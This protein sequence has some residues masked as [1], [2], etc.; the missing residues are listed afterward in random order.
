MALDAT[1][2]RLSS[3]TKLKGKGI[4]L[5]VRQPVFSGEVETVSPSTVNVYGLI[6]GR[7]QTRGVEGNVK[8]DQVVGL[9]AGLVTDDDGTFG[10]ALTLAQGDRIVVGT[11]K[12]LVDDPRPLSPT[13]VA[14]IYQPL[15]TVESSESGVSI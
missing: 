15:L 3:A 7:S 6:F 12:F 13:N 8:S 5:E 11:R 1:S 10:D 4:L 9:I 14:I 2:K